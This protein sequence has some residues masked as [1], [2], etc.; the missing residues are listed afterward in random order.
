MGCI[1]VSDRILIKYSSQPPTYYL[2]DDDEEKYSGI[3]ELFQT[4][5]ETENQAAPFGPRLEISKEKYL[6]LF[7]QWKGA[8]IIKRLEKSVNYRTLNQRLRDLWHLELGF[9]LTDLEEDYYV[10]RFFMRNDYMKVLEGGPWVILGHYLTVTRW[11]PKFWPA[12]KKVTKTL[13]WVRFPG[14]Y[15]E[16]LEEDIISFM[17]D[18]VGKTI[19]VDGTSLTGIRGKFAQCCVEVDLAAPLIPSF[20]VFYEAQKVEYEGLHLICFECGRYGHRGMECPTL[21][22]ID[23]DLIQVNNQLKQSVQGDPIKTTSPY[24]PWMLATYNRRKRQ[25]RHRY[26]RMGTT[27]G[28]ASGKLKT[29]STDMGQDLGLEEP[30]R[31]KGVRN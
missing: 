20:T 17:G 29:L 5:E 18:M 3:D 21:I 19:K 7:K 6:S 22:P 13:V 28:F 23:L 11:K 15:L 24:G 26:E 4:R 25:N 12:A 8:Q 30:R 16:M 1:P 14:V 10:V 9:D 2:G 27:A 31:D